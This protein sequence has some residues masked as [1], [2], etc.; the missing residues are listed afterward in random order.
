M[1]TSGVSGKRQDWAER[2]IRE[3]LRLQL[4]GKQCHIHKGCVSLLE[5]TCAY[6]RETIFTGEC[7]L[8]GERVAVRMA[9]VP[10]DYECIS[11]HRKV[12]D[13]CSDVG[14]MCLIDEG[15]ESHFCI[16]LYEVYLDPITFNDMFRECLFAQ[17]TINLSLSFNDECSSKCEGH[18]SCYDFI[19]RIFKIKG[20][21]LDFSYG[22]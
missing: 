2:I 6:E 1:T 14:C 19:D 21:Q 18:G 16:S 3:G 15:A 10:S 11:V 22:Q 12:S 7:Q 5:D 9:I 13:I 17:T 20:Y 4:R 8:D